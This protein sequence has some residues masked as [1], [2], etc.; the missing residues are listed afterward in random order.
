MAVQQTL[1][2]GLG[3]NFDHNRILEPDEEPTIRRL[4]ARAAKSAI[5]RVQQLYDT[6][7]AANELDGITD[8]KEREKKVLEMRK[9]TKDEVEYLA[10]RLTELVPVGFSEEFEETTRV[11][12]FRQKSNYVK[13]SSHEYFMKDP[14]IAEPPTTSLKDIGSSTLDAETAEITKLDAT[15]SPGEDDEFV[16]TFVKRMKNVVEDGSDDDDD[17]DDDDDKIEMMLA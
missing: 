1:G 7:S 6:A 5:K 3:F 16:E 11:Q 9:R 12:Q 15:S 13:T 2:I 4:Q 8:S 10:R 17:D 14:P